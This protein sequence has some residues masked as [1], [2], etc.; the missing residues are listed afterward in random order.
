MELLEFLQND[1]I[2]QFTDPKKRLFA[3][4]LACAFVIAVLWLSLIRKQ[5]LPTAL[6]T[7][8]A[9]KIWLSRSSR[10]DAVCFVVN[11]GIFFLI[12]PVLLTQIMIA[13]ALYHGLHY[14]SMLPLGVMAST[15][16]WVAATA[17]TVFFFVFDDFS[18]FLTHL[19]LHKIPAL[20][21]FHKFHHSAEHLTPLTVTRAHPVEGI[22][23]TLRSAIVQGVSIAI[24]V[25]LFGNHV[26]LI[27]I[28]GVNVFVVLFHGLG[29]NL[30]HSH[31]AIRYPRAVE[32]I[33][34]SPAQHHLHHSE[35]PKHHDKNFGVA[36][37]VWDRAAGSFHHSTADE[38]QYGIGRETAA[39]TASLWTMYLLPFAALVRRLPL[40]FLLA[41][42]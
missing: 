25:F 42:K 21:A 8:F 23:F 13:T 28:F 24:F 1:I 22:I 38:L 5:S 37:S 18:R 11:R 20:W 32:T 27:T 34:M 36:L 35:N 9:R 41:R 3:G 6:K 17:F 14:Q 15:P 26:N 30:R 33:V 40:P 29:S 16:Y 39:Y 10:F 4:Y 12:R 2:G 7:L 31:I 19:A